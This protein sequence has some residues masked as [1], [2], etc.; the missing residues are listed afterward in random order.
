MPRRYERPLTYKNTVP[1]PAMRQVMG[2]R[3]GEVDSMSS[4]HHLNI[5]IRSKDLPGNMRSTS[6]QPWDMIRTY[7]LLVIYTR[8]R[9]LLIFPSDS[10]N[11]Q[12]EDAHE[13][14][15]ARKDN[16]WGKCKVGADWLARQSPPAQ[17]RMYGR[18]RRR[19]SVA[20]IAPVKH[21]PEPDHEPEMA[22]WEPSI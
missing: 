2:E 9:P 18:N 13:W 17:T 22:S 15:R 20:G 11:K 7:M 12:V 16:C 4:V 3:G 5:V 14:V 19:S 21:S 10:S 8:R 6:I 1:R